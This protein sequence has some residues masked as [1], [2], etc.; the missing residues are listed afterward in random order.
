MVK[1]GRL[2]N[3]AEE[4]EI[5][6][7]E[8]ERAE[9]LEADLN[10]TEGLVAMFGTE[11][12]I[13]CVRCAA[14]VI[15]LAAKDALTD[16]AIDDLVRSAREAVKKIRKPN[17]L[18]DHGFRKP[19][20]DVET[21]WNSAYDMLSALQQLECSPGVRKFMSA[22]H[23]A[24]LPQLCEV[25]EPLK[26]WTKVC[27]GDQTTMSE[28]YIGLL[29]A[30][31]KLRRIHQTSFA[32]PFIRIIQ[33]ALDNRKDLIFRN[34]SFKAALLLDP[35]TWICVK[36][37][38]RESAIT[39]LVGIWEKIDPRSRHRSEDMETTDEVPP[40]PE[41]VYTMLRTLAGV[42]TSG[43]DCS[44]PQIRSDIEAW[45]TGKPTRAADTS[46][47]SYWENQAAVHPKIARLAQVVF[48]APATSCS[49]ERLFSSLKWIYSDLRNR[50][51]SDLLDDIL[52]LRSNMC[53][54]KNS[55]TLENRV[56]KAMAAHN[57][58]E[59]TSPPERTSSPTAS[60]SLGDIPLSSLSTASD[61]NPY[62]LRPE[63]FED[64][65]EPFH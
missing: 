37:E 35:L 3:E 38:N 10:K 23:W 57:I 17:F 5:E 58:R 64:D 14:H 42:T 4:E 63:D 16:P 65:M 29:A 30:E 19:P 26:T 62:D 48:G 56:R 40:E 11:L 31:M 22:T 54:I 61:P 55:Q 43:H 59:P 44:R 18:R 34:A 51:K 13:T 24:Q 8:D 9:E 1:L 52:V 6:E 47:M 20:L 60:S 32:H 28:V 53:R 27:E 25:L 49:V 50:L 21:R 7:E 45:L 33:N 46:P 12:D 39:H 15:N 2:I 41:D 36:G